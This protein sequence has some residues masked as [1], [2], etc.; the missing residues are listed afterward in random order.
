[1]ANGKTL[2]EYAYQVPLAASHFEVKTN[3]GWRPTAYEGEFRVDPQSYELAS[4]TVRTVDPPVGAAFCQA[5]ATLDY[6]RVHIGDSDLLLP[7]QAELQIELKN[8]PETRNA[9]TFANCREYQDRK[10]TRLN[11]SHLGI[12]YA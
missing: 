10:S 7:R 11:S 6:Q 1:M 2:Y 8:G 4:L 12:S 3:T 5:G 9:T